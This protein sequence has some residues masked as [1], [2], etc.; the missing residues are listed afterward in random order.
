MGVKLG[1]FAL[2][3]ERR[4][5]GAGEEEYCGQC[6]D[7]RG[8]EGQD[9]TEYCIIRSFS[10]CSPHHILGRSNQEG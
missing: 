2:R 6:L 1:S 7:L 4:L 10:I 8:R 9:N 5:R 3:K